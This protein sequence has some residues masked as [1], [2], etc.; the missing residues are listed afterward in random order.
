MVCSV[1]TSRV[2]TRVWGPIIDQRTN[3]SRP[4]DSGHNLCQNKTTLGIIWNLTIY[5]INK[6]LADSGKA[7]S[8]STNIVV[9]GEVGNTILNTKVKTVVPPFSVCS[10]HTGVF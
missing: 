1:L 5:I 7:M 6:L 2:M 3:T 8:C 9:T 4:K 10:K